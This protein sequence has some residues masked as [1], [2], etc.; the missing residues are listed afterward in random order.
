MFKYTLCFIIKKDEVL[1]INRNK[2]PWMGRWNGV[3][4]K[5]ENHESS[6]ESI[7]REIYEET[8]I[9]PEDLD[10]VYKGIVTWNDEAFGDRFGLYLYLAYPN[11]DLEF[12][13]PQ[14]TSEGILDFKPLKWVNDFNNMGVCDN[15]PYFLPTS[16]TSNDLHEY[17]CVFVDG[18]LKD[19]IV[20]KLK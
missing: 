4:G 20:K 5:I 14:K 13:Y 8:N 15:I 12:D 10:I 2:K 16:I 3:G 18:Q 6:L 1:M 17:S 9:N 7:K 11:V 19:V